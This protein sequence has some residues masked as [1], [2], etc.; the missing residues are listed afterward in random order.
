MR[1]NY[2]DAMAIVR[3]K[4]KPDLFITFTAN[5]YWD[6]ITRELEPGESFIN[7]P[8][9]CVRVFQMVFSKF[10]ELILVKHFFG[11]FFVKILRII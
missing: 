3:E 8:E 5:P 10:E 11:I 4:G 9:L 1:Q 2:Q 6:E 7:R